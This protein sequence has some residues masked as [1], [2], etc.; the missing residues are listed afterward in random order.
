MRY[1][2]EEELNSSFL[3]RVDMGLLKTRY[4]VLYVII[5]ALLSFGAGALIGNSTGGVFVAMSMVM[6]LISLTRKYR[7]QAFYA[8]YKQ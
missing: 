6:P 2:T 7:P 5:F 1:K 4:K 3:P 8:K